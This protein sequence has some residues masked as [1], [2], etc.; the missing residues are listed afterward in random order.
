MEKSG[1]LA[2]RAQDLVRDLVI[3]IKFPTD[4]E[5]IWNS[6]IPIGKED[7]EVNFSVRLSNKIKVDRILMFKARCHFCSSGLCMVQVFGKKDGEL[8][9][10]VALFRDGNGS[11]QFE[12]HEP[13]GHTRQGFYPI[14]TI[15]P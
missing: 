1:S 3:R 14:G 4:G 2:K 13:R 7:V 8:Y 10:V 9:D 11:R 12:V 5:L 15:M 6:A